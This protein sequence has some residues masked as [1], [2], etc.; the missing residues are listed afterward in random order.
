MSILRNA[1]IAIAAHGLWLQAPAHAQSDDEP[2]EGVRV[3]KTA[4]YAEFDPVTALDLVNRTPGFDAQEQDGGRGLAGVRSNILIDGKRPPPKGQSARQML[5]EMPITGIERIELI[6]AGARLDIDM[7]GF[8]QVVN[9]ITQADRPAYY[10]VITQVQRS[11]TG[12]TDQ[13]NQR[14]V[15]VEAT[16]TFNWNAHQFSV[17]GDMGSR[18]NRS[19]ADFVAIDPENP[20]QR[21]SSLNSFERDDHEVEMRASLELPS[22]S[23]LTLNGGFSTQDSMSYPIALL[24]GDESQ[25]AVDESFDS[26][27]DRQDFSAEYLR[28]T[29]PGGTLMVAVVDSVSNEE[30]ESSLRDGSLFRSSINDRESGET[31]ARVRMVR[32]PTDRLMVRLTA[33]NAFNYFEGGFRLIENGVDQPVEGS[34]SRV[35]EDRRSLETSVDWNWSSRW[36]FRGTLGAEQ[37]EIRSRDLSTGTQTDPRGDVALIFRPRPRTTFTLE[38]RREIGQ[39]SFGRFLASSNLSS[40]I[41]TAGASVLEPERRWVHSAIWDRRFGDVGVLRVALNHE[42]VDN[43]VRQVALSDTLVVSR[44][45]SAQTIDSLQASIEF[46][47]E[48]FGRDDLILQFNGRLSQ[49]ETVDPVTGEIREVSGVNSSFWNVGLRRDPGNSRLAWGMSVSNWNGGDNYSV[50][51]TRTSRQSREWQAY[52]EWEPI[53]DLKFRTRLEGPRRDLRQTSYFDTVRAI[54][55]NPFFYA[56][57]ITS[58]DRS[59]SFTVQWRRSERFEIR[60]SLSTRPK[61]RT[62]ESLTPFGEAAGSLLATE[63]AMAPQASLRFRFYNN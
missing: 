48:R 28:P 5:G 14:S 11:G 1:I 2:T 51:S 10:E 8:P 4:Y 32:S 55:L 34:D 35:E 58:V 54:G 21:I 43:P 18:S 27:Q 46:P 61:V 40:G 41:L 56:D 44:N 57:T 17:T 36:T 63:I 59:A 7:Q 31:A 26:Q 62:V 24:S 38:S 9:V 25:D 37:Y 12:D 60:G 50:R 52:V 20:V 49:S 39:L 47:F 30:S 33:T 42:K 22:E 23:T 6:D 15:G 13:E 45:T 3:F 53:D 16:G 29:G 19:P